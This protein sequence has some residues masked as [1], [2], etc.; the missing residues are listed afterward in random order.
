MTKIHWRVL[1]IVICITGCAPYLAAQGHPDFKAAMQQQ[2]VAISQGGISSFTLN[3]DTPFPSKQF[4]LQ[5]E[6]APAGVTFGPSGTTLPLKAGLGQ[7]L[8]EI[9]AAPNVSAGTFPIYLTI[10][11]HTTGSNDLYRNVAFALRIQPVSLS[12]QAGLAAGPWE[13]TIA[14]AMSPQELVTQ[15]NYLSSQRWEMTQVLI[16]NLSQWVAFFRRPKQ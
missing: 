3:I 5:F 2:T 11:D 12:A 1:L 8:I 7:T 4:D 6:G 16:D 13:Y 15:A 9:H 14:T 10:Y